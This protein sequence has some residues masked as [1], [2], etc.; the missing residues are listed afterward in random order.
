MQPMEQ[1]VV[2]LRIILDRRSGQ[3][4]S[5]PDLPVRE[6]PDV[7]GSKL[8]ALGPSELNP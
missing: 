1:R 2:A 5:S 6:S 3:C 8:A 4:G 7:C